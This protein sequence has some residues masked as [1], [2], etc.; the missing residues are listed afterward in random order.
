MGGIGCMVNIGE[1]LFIFENV[2]QTGFTCVAL[3]LFCVLC[4]SSDSLLR[5]EACQLA[6]VN[7][8]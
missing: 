5:R 6:R 1:F 4:V 2:I 3:S 8:N 7:V